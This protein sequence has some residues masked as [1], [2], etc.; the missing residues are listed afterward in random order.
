MLLEPRKPVL[1]KKSSINRE[2]KVNHKPMRKV[3]IICDDPDATDSSDDEK[4]LEREKRVKRIVHEVHF[5]ICDS[6]RVL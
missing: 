3:R 4:E 1:L 6:S 5:P 2:A